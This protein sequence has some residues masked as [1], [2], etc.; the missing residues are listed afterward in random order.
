MLASLL[1]AKIK[2]TPYKMLGNIVCFPEETPT[3]TS[4]ICFT[5]IF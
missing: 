4:G 3:E 2:P 5:I 1:G